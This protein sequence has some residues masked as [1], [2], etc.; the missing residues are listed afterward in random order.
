M[1]KSEYN[2][3]TTV[4]DIVVA[5]VSLPLLLTHTIMYK[6]LR[7]VSIAFTCRSQSTAFSWL[8]GPYGNDIGEESLLE[9]LIPL[10]LLLLV[11]M[12]KLAF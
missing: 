5:L 11:V 3:K 2:T 10:G 8:S 1:A 12:E 4:P 6:A 7:I 9:F